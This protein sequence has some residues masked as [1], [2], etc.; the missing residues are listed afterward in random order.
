MPHTSQ[1]SRYPNQQAI[2]ASWVHMTNKSH[3][4]TAVHTQGRQTSSIRRVRDLVQPFLLLYRSQAARMAHKKQLHSTADDLFLAR[5]CRFSCVRRRSSPSKLGD[6]GLSSLP[7]AFASCLKS[8][9]SHVTKTASVS[10]TAFIHTAAGKYVRVSV[11]GV[12]AYTPAGVCDFPATPPRSPPDSALLGR[13]WFRRGTQ[14]VPSW[15]SRERVE[16]DEVCLN[17]LVICERS[18][19]RK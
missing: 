14:R 3:R 15:F 5:S 4:Y 8:C 16:T 13:H 12:A 2:A 11:V 18:N 6:D 7:L 10:H 19:D 1:T 17:Q 9:P